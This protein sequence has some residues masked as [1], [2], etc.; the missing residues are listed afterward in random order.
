MSEDRPLER[1]RARRGLGARSPEGATSPATPK[2]RLQHLGNPG[3]EG[4]G[5]G[6]KA[7]A[8]RA[9]RARRRSVRDNPD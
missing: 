7:R 9:A 1:E 4:K 3:A 6:K 5:G 2:G 8:P